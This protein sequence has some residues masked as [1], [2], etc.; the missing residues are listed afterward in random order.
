M[1]VLARAVTYAVLFIGLVLICTGQ[2]FILV[3]HCLPSKYWSATD[4]WSDRRSCGCGDSAMVCIYFFDYRKRDSG[5][6][7]STAP[8]GDS[9]SLSFCAESHVHWGRSCSRQRGALL[10]VF[11]ASGLHLCLLS[12]HSPVRDV[13]RRA[14]AATNFRAGL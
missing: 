14:D 12:H 6:V 5:T 13:L 4:C 2:Y 10:R 1:F 9:G 7:R 8:A 3:G 11:A